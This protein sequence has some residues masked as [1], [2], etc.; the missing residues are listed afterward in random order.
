MLAVAS[1]PAGPGPVYRD[2][3]LIGLLG[4]LDP[5]RGDVA[6]AIADCH[7]AGRDGIHAGTSAEVII[8]FEG[9]DRLACQVCHIP[10]FARQVAT[11]TVWNW[12]TA[13]QDIP[14]EE[15][16]VYTDPDGNEYP[17]YNKM[18]GDFEFANNVRPELRYHNGT[19]TKTI[20]NV[21]DQ[22]VEQPVVLSE[23]VGDYTEEDS[24]IYP[25]KKMVG[26]QVADTV[27][28]RIMVPHLFGTATGPNPYWGGFDWNL[29]IQ[30]GANYTGQPY[31][32]TFGFVDTFMFLKVDHEVAPKE[33]AYGMN[34]ACADCHAPGLID[35][36]LLG[37]DADP[38]T[39]GG[40]RP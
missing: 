22:F 10:T 17:L 18:T 32:G 38:V 23:P 21:N 29:A 14:A 13:G 40:T 12:E 3:N 11:K 2:L 25:F 39:G 16:P 15:I 33:Q 26:N 9:H 28:Q 4:L 24:M 19:W 37:Y 5:A 27:N 30:D 35:W 31:S 7:T 1:K 34:G 6:E 20:M 8:A 36:T